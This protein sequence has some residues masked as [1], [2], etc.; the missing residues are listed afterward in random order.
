MLDLCKGRLI[1]SE[2]KGRD[3]I[4]PSQKLGKKKLNVAKKNKF[5]LM[6]WTIDCDNIKKDLFLTKILF[7]KF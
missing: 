3:S 4:F 5:N 7:K 1:P 2:K 6:E